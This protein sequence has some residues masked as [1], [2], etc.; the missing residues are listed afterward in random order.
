MRAT[1][2]CALLLMAL[3]VLF[4]PGCWGSRETDETAYVL[5]VGLDEGEKENLMV[6]FSIANPKVI[7]G[8]SSGAG[9]G[10]NNGGG[11]EKKDKGTIVLSVETSSLLGAIDLINT[12]IDRKISLLHTKAFIFSENLARQGLG[13]WI[14]PLHRYRELRA[15]SQMFVCRGKARDF[16]EKNDPLLELSPTKQFELIHK[17]SHEHG[18]FASIQF[19]EFYDSLKSF[20]KQGT[21]PMVALREGETGKVKQGLSKSNDVAP[22]KYIA[23]EVPISGGNKAQA[24]GSGVF[25]GDRMVGIISGQETRYYLMLDGRFKSGICVIPDPLSTELATVDLMLHQA[26]KPTYKVNISGDGTV[27]VGIDIYLEPEIY[28]IMSGNN[29]ES[30]ELKP[31]LEDAFSEF[32]KQGCLDLIRRTQEEFQSDIFGFGN[33]V[34]HRFLTVQS[35]TE[36][37][38]K[39]KFP[40]VQAD[41]TVHTRI[42]RTGLLLKT[43]PE[44]G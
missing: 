16:I 12:N 42:R 9:G 24:I 17:I 33:H 1:R 13:K 29:Y 4:L 37:D 43:S 30:L 21:I 38:W 5:A 44:K 14:L 27:F 31:V 23:G 25:R 35:W 19:R 7:A 39:S 10:D 28:S 20:S 18:L 6:T 36:F 11:G 15:T 8:I 32:I 2:F 22:G 41:V 3:L 26:R 40:D 34:K